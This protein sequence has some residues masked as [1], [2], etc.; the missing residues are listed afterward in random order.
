MD[1]AAFG[2]VVPEADAVNVVVGNPD[3]IVVAV[4]FGIVRM[5]H[6]RE[7]TAG[8]AD[9]GK[10]EGAAEVGAEMIAGDFVAVALEGDLVVGQGDG[11][12]TRHGVG[13]TNNQAPR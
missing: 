1:D 2:A 11:L 4:R 13:S 6:A 8:G 9:D 3:R 7:R 10:E 5:A 12:E